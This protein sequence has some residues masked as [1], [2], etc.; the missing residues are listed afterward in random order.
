MKTRICG[1]VS[2]AALAGST[3]WAQSSATLYG[4]VDLGY[5]YQSGGPHGASNKL[6]NSGISS[7]SRL[8]FRGTEDLGDGL[9]AV[10]WLEMGVGADAGTFT[11][12][13][14]PFGR[15]S[16][17]G[18]TSQY[19]TVMLGRQ[20][21]PVAIVQTETDP[22]QTGL[23]GTS[24][25]LISAGGA[26][27]NN[28]L[29]NAV[30]Y[31]YSGSSG[32]TFDSVYGF[33]EV[34][35]NFQANRQ[36]GASF[37]Y[38]KG[39]AYVKVGYADVNNANGVGGWMSFLGARYDF[40][41]ATGY[42]NY[43]IN[44]GSQVFGIPNP[45]S[46]DV[47]VGVSVPIGAHQIMASYIHKDDRTKADNSASQ[48]A[49]GYMYWLSKRTNVYTSIARID[50]HSEALPSTYLYRVGNATTQGIGS[51]AFN[52]GMRTAF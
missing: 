28:R 1:L 50:N 18:L 16:A 44:K 32:F 29:D 47:L 46:R 34:V 11:Q 14:I 31:S 36:V 45:N 48:L 38:V 35:N 19:G 49:I 23:A 26:G 9:A 25:N 37:G 5:I 33:G 8:G 40:K 42:L 13:G 7:G 24:A 10:Y 20:Y 43:V 3:C 22:F 6:L 21:T 27:G 4:V 30:R 51:R 17:V 15:Q 41:V 12:G 2:V 39:P 52:V